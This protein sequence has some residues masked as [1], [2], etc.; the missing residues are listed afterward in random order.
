VDLTRSTRTRYSSS[1]PSVVEVRADGVVTAVAPG[2]AEVPE[3]TVTYGLLKLVI[4][5]G[6]RSAK[7]P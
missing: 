5:A 2:L 6:V 3:I 1:D 4:R 7:Q